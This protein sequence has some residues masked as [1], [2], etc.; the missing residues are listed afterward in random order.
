MYSVIL[1]IHHYLAF[2]AL[3]LLAWATLNGIMGNSSEKLFEE[4]HRKTNVFALIATHTMLLIGIVLLL[5]SPIAQMA[6]SDMGAAMKDSVIRKAVVEH[7]TVNI[8]AAVLVTVGNAKVKRATGNGKKFKTTMIFFGA[9]L[10]LILS[11]LPFEK[12]F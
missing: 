4:S 10:I 12:L 7:P 6:F 9:A 11:R 8:I 1:T 3:V 2:I 5:V